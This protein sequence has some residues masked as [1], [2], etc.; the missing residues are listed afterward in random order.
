MLA[1]TAATGKLGRH[2]VEGLLARIPAADLAVVVRDPGKAADLAARGVRVRRGDYAAPETLVPALAGVD[3]VLL[4]SSNDVGHRLAHHRAVV[5]AAK[6]A[7]VLLLAYTSILRADTSGIGLAAEH[8]DTEALIRASGLPFTFLR[9]GWYLENYTENLA[10]ALRHG[11][12]LGCAALGRVAAAARADY[13]AAAV[14]V[15]TGEGHENRV[16][17]LAGD[18]PF[19]MAELAAEVSR[20]AGKTVAYRDLPP[21]EC[22][23]ALVAAGLPGPVADLLVDWDLGVARGDL[24]GSSADLR[25]LTGRAST[26]LAAAVA[27][28]LR[29]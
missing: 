24:D 16:Y 21:A 12:M 23:A 5:D 17:E 19:T 20:Q 22:R 15:L 13:A 26:P 14:A 6:S 4:I 9:N 28:A 7:E 27:A 10:P 18:A 11:V 2:V 3:K 25:R 8:R 29:R 1:V